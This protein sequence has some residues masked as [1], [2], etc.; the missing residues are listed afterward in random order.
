MEHRSGIYVITN[1]INGKQY[2]GQ[3]I[4]IDKRIKQHFRDLKA[5]RDSSHMQ[6][7][8]N[9]YGKEA[10]A[11]DIIE[12]CDID[13][14]DDREIYWIAE[15]DTF[16]NGYN[17]TLGGVGTRGHTISEET[18]EK[19]RNRP[20]HRGKDSPLY[21]TS[22]KDR[23]SPEKYAEAVKH[24]SESLRKVHPR[25]KPVTCLNDKRTFGCAREASEFYNITIG[26]ITRLCRNGVGRTFIKDENG[27]PYVFVLAEKFK[28]MSD[29]DIANRLEIE[30]NR[31]SGSSHHNAKVIVNLNT[32]EVFDCMRDAAASCDIGPTNISSCL[33][34]IT[35]GAG[36]DN[37]GRRIA[38]AYYDDYVKMSNEDIE[39]K[40]ADVNTFFGPGAKNNCV[41][42][43]RCKTTGEEFGSTTECATFYGI[44]ITCVSRCCKGKQRC[45]HTKDGTE[46]TFEYITYS[47]TR[48]PTDAGLG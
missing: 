8:Y 16:E 41:K 1:T 23:L 34:G 13:K 12:Y 39:K 47:D 15:L 28:E 10:F 4:D 14:L 33:R 30:L 21:V 38:W 27:Y 22:L 36:W 5:G 31:N 45:A 7:A 11:A 3:S 43:V 20:R 48:V 42:P 29:E 25:G 9:L 40:I 35:S 2:V 44:D 24:L 46:L 37:D 26:E 18:R 17:L 19:F 32:R 6:R